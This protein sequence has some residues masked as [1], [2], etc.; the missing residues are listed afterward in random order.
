MSKEKLAEK[1][2]TEEFEK[3]L[4]FHGK[5]KNA[6]FVKYEN[7]DIAAA[8]KYYDYQNINTYIDKIS[9]VLN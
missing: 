5:E 3:C 7:F 4:N 1:L 8:C 9:D 2:L 6:D